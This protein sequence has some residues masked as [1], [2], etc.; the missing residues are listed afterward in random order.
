VAGPRFRLL[1][2]D[3]KARSTVFVRTVGQQ[4][5]GRSQRQENMFGVNG[6]RL[7]ALQSYAPECVNVTVTIVMLRRE[8]PLRSSSHLLN[9]LP[10][11]IPFTKVKPNR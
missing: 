4:S 11:N 10:R 1:T 8:E 6:I 7:Q 9:S 2:V 5:I 3:G